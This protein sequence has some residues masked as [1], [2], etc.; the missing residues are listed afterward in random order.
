[1]KK[2]L[3]ILLLA[4]VVGM[5]SCASD[6]DDIFDKS[7]AQRAKQTLKEDM[8]I[9]ASAK[10]GWNLVM[11]ADPEDEIGFG[12]YN[13]FIKF[14]EDGSVD[15]SSELGESDKIVNSH[16]H[17]RCDQSQ[18]IILSFDEYNEFIHFFSDPANPMGLGQKGQGLKGDIEFSILKATKE[19]VILKG[20]KSGIKLRMTPV[21][22]DRT[23][24]Q[25]I[26]SI[27][28]VYHNMGRYTSYELKLPNKEESIILLREYRTLYYEN[29]N[30]ETERIPYV[31]TKEG[32]EFLENAN[33]A[34]YNISGFEFQN[35]ATSFYAKGNKE[36]KLTARVLPIVT[37]FE[38]GNWF[39][40]VS[41]MSATVANTFKTSAYY[42]NT[43][44]DFLNVVY[45]YLNYN[46]KDK[47]FVNTMN[48][49]GY[50]GKIQFNYNAIDGENVEFGYSGVDEKGKPTHSVDANGAVFYNYG[51]TLFAQILNDTFTLVPD[52]IVDPQTITFVSKE[53]PS[54]YFTVYKKTITDPL[55]N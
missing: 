5:A 43:Y 18:G 47:C 1:M 52:D 54:I 37:I 55:N 41:G 2:I 13:L 30:G 7:S 23:W 35:G 29:E 22:E 21:A 42:L 48:C 26:D 19:E 16:S 6:V 20:K 34:G 51:F 3:N 38:N 12:A 14:N 49:G 50:L 9:L 46:S 36:I 25:E 33:I 15:V 28:S 44:F 27:K 11:K 39:F 17:F 8:E 4:L 31:I 24:Q 10:N 45:S 32:I 53:D 40:A